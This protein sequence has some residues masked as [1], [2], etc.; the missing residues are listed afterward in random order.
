[1]KDR[2][3]TY[4]GRVKL[5]PV[6][7]QPNTYDME[8]ADE[9]IQEGTPINK[10]TLLNDD[11]ASSLGLDEQATVNEAIFRINQ[12]K[13]AYS[14]WSQ[15]LTAGAD[16]LLCK[17]FPAATYGAFLLNVVYA[18]NAVSVSDVY[19][20]S[21]AYGSINIAKISDGGYT[22][23]NERTVK[24]WA[25]SNA[26]GGNGGG[27]VI[28]LNPKFLDVSSAIAYCYYVPLT[29]NMGFLQCE[30]GEQTVPTGF[31][32]YKSLATRNGKTLVDAN[33]TEDTYN[34]GNFYR[35]V[36]GVKEWL[37]PPFIA[38]V[39]YRTTE[40]HLGKVVY[41]KN[42]DCGICGQGRTSIA[43][44]LPSTYKIVRY[45]SEGS[46]FFYGDQ[47]P[48]YNQYDF[49]VSVMNSAINVH[50]IASG[51]SQ[52]YCTVFYTKD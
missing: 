14:R 15:T 35:M 27:I 34:S 52:Y 44:N 32:E 48:G 26:F 30:A 25:K 24:A 9:P 13:L 2:I 38:N 22:S 17:I 51:E 49:W 29:S 39:E 23:G 11:T 21:M 1:M 6:S 33:F 42:F 47:K 16:T 31:K 7:N 4:A 41:A 3:P 43:I 12:L 20:V 37:N 46:P 5:M 40:R 36:D 45:F 10:E 19:A 28:T 50:R 18:A 8:R